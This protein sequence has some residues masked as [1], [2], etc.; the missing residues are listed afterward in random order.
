MNRVCTGYLGKRRYT[1]YLVFVLCVTLFSGLLLP[2]SGESLAGA[3]EAS[4]RNWS[5]TQRDL[6]RLDGKERD[7]LAELFKLT[8]DTQQIMQTRVETEKA[9]AE[10]RWHVEQ[11]ADQVARSKQH[12]LDSSYMATGALRTL[13]RLGPASYLEILLGASTLKDFF[14]RVD[15]VTV[16]IKGFTKVLNN[17]REE[18]SRLLSNEEKLR[19]EQSN[20]DIMLKQLTE[21]LS[22]LD[23]IRLQ[24]E[25]ILDTTGEQ[26]AV[27][28]ERL[29]EIEGRWQ[30]A[31]MIY[32]ENLSESFAQITERNTFDLPEMRIEPGL[33][34]LHMII[35]LAD[36]NKLF[37]EE[38]GLVGVSLIAGDEQLVLDAPGES[39]QLIG[40]FELASVSGIRYRVDRV[41]FTG[42]ELPPTSLVGVVQQQLIEVDFTRL[43][44]GLRI[45]G[46]TTK[47]AAVDLHLGF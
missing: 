23:R 22:A 45:I 40:N 15:M 38:P 13:Q 42:I 26:K 2:G 20:L 30:E 16:A 5:E 17:L 27:I 46:V 43:L 33:D 21:Q 36:L 39:L 24:Q 29:G 47:G 10:L 11:A 32:L 14:R 25:A 31:T 19:R 6:D 34:G 44:A 4:A 3:E 1:K 41:R 9:A 8:L 35:T 37:Q 28:A 7:A 12:Y 18:K